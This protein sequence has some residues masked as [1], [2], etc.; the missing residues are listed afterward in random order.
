MS[1]G[2]AALTHLASKF[3][4]AENTLAAACCGGNHLGPG[5]AWVEMH[6]MQ[7]IGDSYSRS[8]TAAR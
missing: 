3:E 7:K 2:F 8:T 5:A 6:T 1:I 4:G